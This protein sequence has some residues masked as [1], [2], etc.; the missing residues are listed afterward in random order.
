MSTLAEL[1]TAANERQRQG[2]PAGAEQLFRSALAADPNHAL[3][4]NAL[5]SALGQ[6]GRLDEAIECLQRAVTLQ[7]ALAEA[8]ANLATAAI[9]QRNWDEARARWRRAVELQPDYVDAQVNLATL[10]TRRQQWDEAIDHWRRVAELQPDNATALTQLATLAARQNQLEEAA[11]CWR[12]LLQR[13]PNSAEIHNNLGAALQGL[14]RLDEAGACWRRAVELNP[15][16]A[17]AH[18][19][20]G[21]ICEWEGRLEE[22]AVCYRRARTIKTE[23]FE[24]HGNLGAVLEKLGQWEEALACFWRAVELRSNSD[25]AWR[26]LG[27]ALAKQDQLAEADISYQRAL[28]LAPDSAVTFNDWAG[29]LR[30]QERWEQAATLVRRALE[31]DPHLAKAQMHLGSILELQGQLNEAETWLRRAVEEQPDLAEAYH[32]LGAMLVRQGRLDEGIAA[33]EKALAA[34]PDQPISSSAILFALQYQQGATLAKLASAHADFDARY[35]VP[36][37]GTWRPHENQVDLDRPLRLGFVSADFGPHPVSY[38]L[39]RP[40]EHLDR[41]KFETWCY[42]DHARS[43]PM[44]RLRAAATQWRSSGRWSD[45]QLADQIRADRIDIL[46]DLA[47]HT[48]HNRMLLFARKPAP[49]QITWIGYEG[50]TG[51]KAMDYL[52]ADRHEIPESAEPYITERVLRMPDGCFCFDPPA[53]APPVSPLPALSRG[54]V[55]FASFNN[56]AK[57]TT[58][59]IALW[60]A[61]LDRVAGSRLVLKYR[62]LDTPEVGGRIAGMFAEHGVEPSRLEF[63]GRSSYAE[64]LRAYDRIDLALDPFPFNGGATTC[65]ALWMGVP[66]IT[67]PGETFASRHSLTHLSNVGLTETIARDREEYLDIAARLAADLP[68]LATIR[69][70]LRPQMAASPLCNGRR[71]AENLMPLLRNVWRQWCE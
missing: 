63:L 18:N 62:W 15:Q 33:F 13:E 64:M 66:V 42:C 39:I 38:F 21:A 52:L 37:R 30:R 50:S 6:Q 68:R 36:L 31:L 12:R 44:P 26:N 7:P 70:Q 22:A 49:I 9:H 25:T 59:V 23:F 2:D 29:V 43:N 32:N 46:F 34:K 45:Q 55:T 8:H 61:V 71:F 3:A 17:E 47:G 5:G 10:A 19:N 20:L 56:P 24:A 57:L 1:L 69:A 41:R 60:A 28:E 67:W 65:D 51:L 54:T 14:G 4:W 35:A 53:E 58:D 11:T 27:A 40:L 16:L 48:A